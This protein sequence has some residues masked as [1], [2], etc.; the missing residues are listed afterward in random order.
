MES[1]YVLWADGTG[2]KKQVNVGNE[3]KKNSK[4]MLGLGLSYSW[5]DSDAIY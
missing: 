2:L 4:I 3:E 1:R 5:V